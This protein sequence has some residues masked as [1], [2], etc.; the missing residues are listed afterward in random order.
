MNSNTKL[1]RASV[2]GKFSANTLNKPSFFR[3]QELCQFEKSPK[4]TLTEFREN[5]DKP[6]AFWWRKNLFFQLYW[7]TFKKGLN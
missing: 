5:P 2:I 1:F 3:F 4:M 7:M 6:E